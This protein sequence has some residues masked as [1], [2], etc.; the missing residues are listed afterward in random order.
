MPAVALPVVTTP[1]VDAVDTAAEREGRHRCAN[2]ALDTDR[3]P[4]RVEVLQVRAHP[5]GRAITP[6]RRL[7]GVAE[8]VVLPRRF[9]EQLPSLDGAMSWHET[10]VP[11]RERDVHCRAKSVVCPGW[12]AR[13]WRAVKV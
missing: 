7:L 10:R 12:P 9:D 5:P 1:Q 13:W 11:A 4:P 3:L 2:R 8:S 6:T